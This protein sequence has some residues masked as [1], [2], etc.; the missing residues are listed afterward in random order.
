[1]GREIVYCGDCGRRLSEDEFDRGHAHFVE[2]RPYCSD[3][4]ALPAAAPRKS[5]PQLPIP[6]LTPRRAMAAAGGPPPPKPP[7]RA[8]LLIGLTVGAVALVAIVGAI[9]SGG[10]GGPPPSPVEVQK[11]PAD[12]LLPAIQ[13]LEKFA[14]S[15]AEPEAI[16]TRCD[17]ERPTLANSKYRD[18]FAKVETA[19]RNQ[20]G[21][22]DKTA[23]FD[24]ALSDIKKVIASDTDF[25]RR[26]ETLERLR[27]AK[28]LAGSRA[29]EV[30]SI[31]ADYNASFLAARKRQ[32]VVLSAEGATRKGTNLQLKG[33]YLGNW[34]TP[35]DYLEWTFETTW[36]GSYRV[37]LVYSCGAAAGGD[38]SVAAGA[39]ALKASVAPTGDFK[40]YQTVTS[41]TLVLPQGRVTLTLK[42]SSV[43]GGGLMN[44]KTLT[45]TPAP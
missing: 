25:L 43:K 7:S 44:L 45:L 31:L 10:R 23:Q 39:A 17:R 9:S 24:F 32:P 42:P 6:A 21:A 40:K 30:D 35:A 2:N 5:S 8:P 19:A 28:G 37:D 33:D 14:S 29:P 15:G 38:Y 22:R 16:L 11:A 34:K 36:A 13:A 27:K 12:D 20:K 3:C 26:D 1:M 41:G 4:R 18:R